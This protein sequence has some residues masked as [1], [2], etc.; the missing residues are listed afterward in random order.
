MGGT[1]ASPAAAQVSSRPEE[2]DRQA[3]HLSSIPADTRSDDFLLHV[4][5]APVSCK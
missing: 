5:V 2:G 1:A 4:S 3:I